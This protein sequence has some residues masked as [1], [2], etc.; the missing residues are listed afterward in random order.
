MDLVTEQM[1]RVEDGQV[2][3]HPPLGRPVSTLSYCLPRNRGVLVSC[4]ITP[5]LRTFWE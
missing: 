2:H 3:R 5:L 4:V 1:L